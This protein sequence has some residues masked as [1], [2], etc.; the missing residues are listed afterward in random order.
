LII[1]LAIFG[2]MMVVN[3]EMLVLLED[4]MDYKELKVFREP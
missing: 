4:Q 3:G 1:I 2:Y